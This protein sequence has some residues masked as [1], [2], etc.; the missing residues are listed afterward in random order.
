MNI[1]VFGAG[2]IGSLFGGLLAKKNMVVL[3]GRSQHIRCIQQK[4]LQIRGKTHLTTMMSAVESI[5]EISLTPDVIILTVKSYDTET[6]CNQ[7]RPLLQ[8]GTLVVSLQ[9]GLDNIEKIERI[10]GKK[11]ILA[12]VT[13][14]GAFF[15]KP[16]IIIHT[17]RGTTYLGELDG[18]PSK[19]LEN[20]HRTFNEVGLVTQMSTDIIGEIW[21]KAIINSSIN[22]LTA[23]F[24]CKNGYLLENP[25]LEKTVE[26]I[27]IESCRI[28]SLKGIQVSPTEMIRKTKEVIQETAQNSSSMLQSIQQGKKTEI[29]SINGTLMR[30]GRERKI[31]VSMNRILFE[32]IHSLNPIPIKNRRIK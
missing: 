16:G 23:F 21:R 6:A 15:E 11:H 31:D 28:A 19:R 7:I 12:G 10:I 22:P 4:G 14:H 24:G 2:A 25:L 3:V 1:V 9:N 29:D 8:D 32:L 17:G 27:C 30:I 26:L 18:R 5:T 20:L 13:T